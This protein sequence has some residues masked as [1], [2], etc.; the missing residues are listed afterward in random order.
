MSQIY[1]RFERKG[2]K[3]N[4][5]F[6]EQYLPKI[7][8]RREQSGIDDMLTEMRGIMVQV[9]KNE[10]I[11][12]L[13]ELSIMTPYRLE[14]S[15]IGDSHRIFI[16]KST[17]IKYP[18]FIVLEPI[19]DSY[20]SRFAG[21]NNVFPRASEK[22]NVKYLGEIYHTKNAPETKKA[23]ESHKVRFYESNELNNRFLANPNFV[24]S[25]ISY[26]TNNLI[27]YSEH[28]LN[29]TDALQ[30]GEPYTLTP[31]EQEKLT[32]AHEIQT[33]LGISGLIRGVD[34][35]ATRVLSG[36]R[37]HAIL[38]LMT[39]TNYYFW[40]AYNIEEMNSSTNVSRNPHITDDELVSPAKVITANNTPF[41]V[42]SFDGKPSPTEDFVRNFGKRMHHMAYEVIDGEQD[43]G[44]KNI[45]FVVGKLNAD[46]AIPFLAK[47]IGECTD[48]PDLK[49]IFSKSSQYSF[50]ITEYVQRCH[51]FDGFFTKDNVA[52]LTEAAGEDEALKKA[53][54]GDA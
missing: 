40:G 8:D 18:R 36:D 23:L 51:G 9:Q 35:L 4:S 38:E 34:H 10:A 19:S 29:D 20:T 37:E 43:N 21:I 48:F 26:F 3:K 45:D 13:A 1:E 14:A 52:A 22:T 54:V 5:P 17:D 44:F 2:D 15:Y 12:Y 16:L 32:K 33:A 27:V 6:F 49:Q 42:T 53:V 50:L 41:Y 11:D 47:V 24:C 31:E 46:A 7:Y 28:D 39:M 30:L 25:A